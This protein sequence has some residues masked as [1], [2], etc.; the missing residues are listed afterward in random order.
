[1]AVGENRMSPGV[2]NRGSLTGALCAFRG[3]NLKALVALNRRFLTCFH[4]SFSLMA[5]FAPPLFS[6]PLHP[7][8]P[9][10]KCVLLGE[11]HS[12]ELGEGQFQDGPLH[13]VREGNSFLKNLLEKGSDSE[14]R[15][16]QFLIVVR[17]ELCD[18]SCSWEFLKGTCP[19]GHP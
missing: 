6:A 15:I 7:S 2:E 3:G 18:L 17:F 1:M 9:L 19:K 10:E 14:S 11:E 4:A 12:R 8:L 13:K 16:G 5:P